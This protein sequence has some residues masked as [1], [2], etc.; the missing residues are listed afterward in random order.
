MQRSLVQL[1]IKGTGLTYSWHCS[2]GG[3]NRMLHKAY[4]L[5]NEWDSCCEEKVFKN[6]PKQNRIL[7]KIRTDIS[8]C[9]W[10]SLSSY[11]L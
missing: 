10:E 4:A 1:A 9:D 7:Q 6:K 8:V 2:N 3:C 5:W 11:Q